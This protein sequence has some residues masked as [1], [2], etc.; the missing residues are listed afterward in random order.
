MHHVKLSRESKFYSAFGSYDRQ[1]RQRFTPFDHLTAE[2]HPPAAKNPGKDV[3]EFELPINDEAICPSTYGVLQSRPSR[4]TQRKYYRSRTICLDRS[5][6]LNGQEKQ[7]KIDSHV[8][9][10][11][12]RM[13]SGPLDGRHYFEHMQH[14]T[15][16]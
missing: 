15:R 2:T 8:L 9:R 1:A 14:R 3:I 5:N 4:R 6:Y 12:R 10:V 11:R 7:H 13:H 16:S